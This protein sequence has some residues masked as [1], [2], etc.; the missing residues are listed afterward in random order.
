V[1]VGRFATPRMN[2][3]TWVLV[4]Y[5]APSALLFIGLVV[6]VSIDVAFGVIRRRS[7]LT[8]DAMRTLDGGAAP[9]RNAVHARSRPAVREPT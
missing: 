7:S 4:A 6:A 1:D 9:R 8:P 5:L 2:A 3:F